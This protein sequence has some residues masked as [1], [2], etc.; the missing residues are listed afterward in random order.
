[1]VLKEKVAIITGAGN[2][3]GRETAILFAKEG[4]IVVATDINENDVRKTVEHVHENG[5]EG[6]FIRHDISKEEDWN[7]VVNTTIEKYGKIDV[8]FNNAGTFMIKPL[9]ETT[10]EDWNKLMSINVNGTFLG[11]KYVMKVMM[12]QKHGSII[13]TSSTAGLVGSPGVSLYGASKGSIRALSKHAAVEGAPYNIRVNSIY[14][15]FVATGMLGQRSETEE[16]EENELAQK[17]PLNRVGETAEVAQ[18]VLFLA[19]EKSSYTTGAEFVIDGGRSM[20]K[21]Y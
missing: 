1:M 5:G 20:D 16:S 7:N 21:S 2:G 11:L 6:I 18:T 15:G 19:S 8:L 3:I 13:N 10:L 9:I 4:A 14:P 12:T 17:V